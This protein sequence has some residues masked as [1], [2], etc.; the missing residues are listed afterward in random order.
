MNDGAVGLAVWPS[1]HSWLLLRT[2]D[3]W[4][5][6]ENRTPVAV[7]TGG[8]LVTAVAA[9]SIAVAVGPYDRLTQSPVLSGGTTGVWRPTELPGA[10]S[11]ARSAVSLAAGRVSAVLAGAR[12]TVVSQ[13]GNRWTRL[14]DASSLAPGG[15]L[16][17][18][19]VTWA[20]ETLGWLTGHGRAGAA[21][22][23]QT[24][25]AG[26][27]WSALRHGAAVAALAPCG[28]R[29]DWLLPIISGDGT[30]R[31]DHTIDGGRTWTTGAPVRLSSGPP[32]WGCRENLVWMAGRAGP[33]NRV[34]ASSD[35][36][37]TWLD[38]GA[39]PPGLTDLTPTGD[40]TGFAAS[41]TSHG[42]TL[43][44]V[45]AD[46]AQFTSLE[47]PGWVATLGSQMTNS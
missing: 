20:S 32:A 12:G 42:P 8:G 29:A 37:A 9:K 6:V 33:G 11:N 31:V 2:S 18:D 14:T 15:G 10:V 16:R 19:G 27:S 46:G 44:S 47:L 41:T 13:T 40:G 28:N 34:F 4:K 5:H 7:P 39:A 25:D 30:V 21:V 22:A 17:L 26:H 45:T 35:A 3:G 24:T 36:G 43:W 23:F 38:A 1:G